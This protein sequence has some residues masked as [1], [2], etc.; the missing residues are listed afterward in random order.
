[1]CKI[2]AF[3]P[4]KPTYLED[5]GFLWEVTQLVLGSGTETPS[6]ELIHMDSRR[7]Y[8]GGTPTLKNNAAT[9]K[10]TLSVC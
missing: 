7:E 3:S 6:F 8:R 10:A 9:Q 4:Q 5:R 1:M 2:C